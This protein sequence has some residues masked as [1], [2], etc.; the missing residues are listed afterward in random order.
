MPNYKKTK[1]KKEQPTPYLLIPKH[2]L[3]SKAYSELKPS[4]KIAYIGLLTFWLRKVVKKEVCYKVKICYS[5]LER[6]TG[7]GTTSIWRGIKELKAKKFILSENHSYRYQI[8]EYELNPL[9]L[10]MRNKK[11]IEESSTNNT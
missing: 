2:T 8:A 3:M 7:L 9:Y 1:D 4:S 6:V 11:P 10:D 5:E